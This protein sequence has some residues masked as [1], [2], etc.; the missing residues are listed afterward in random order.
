MSASTA[1]PLPA[2]LQPPVFLSASVPL[3]DRNRIYFDTADP[4]AIRDA[5]VA[6]A[7]AV[8][9]TTGIVFGGHPAITPLI[10]DVANRL[11]GQV[12]GRVI[13]FQSSLFVSSL[14]QHPM[15]AGVITPSGATRDDSLRIMRT[16]M[17][18][19]YPQF[20]AGVFIG[21]MEGVR[22]EFLQFRSLH[23]QTLLLPVA[24]AGAAAAMIF[25]QET[26]PGGWPDGLRDDI[27]Y[28]SLFRRLLGL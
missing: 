7:T 3:I 27:A 23:P 16:A 5:A 12:I 28:L 18:T 24:S 14:P 2:F 4:I 10:S 25:D 13:L 11:S 8:L 17:M 20:M 1:R 15:I 22:D 6:L 21:G 26:P 19:S 9:P